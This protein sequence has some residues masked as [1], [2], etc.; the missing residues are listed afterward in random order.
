[1]QK[2]KKVKKIKQT[3]QAKKFQRVI[4]KQRY[5]SMDSERSLL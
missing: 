3:K 2:T 4:D 1:M 5:W